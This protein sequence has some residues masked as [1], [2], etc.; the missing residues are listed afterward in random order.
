MGL[1]DRATPSRNGA[2]DLVCLLLFFASRLAAQQYSHLSG[3]IL[4]PSEAGVPGA[5][6]SAINEDTGFR[7]IAYSRSDGGYTVASLEPGVYKITVRKA[8]FR[9]L[10]RF[11]VKIEVSQPARL[12]FTLPVGSMQEAITVEGAAPLLNSED[13]SVG[14]LVARDEIENLPLNGRGLISLIDLAPG[15]IVTPATR[16]EAG[17]FTVNGQRPNT[18]YFMVDGVSAN[19]GVSAGGLPAQSTGGSLP[20]MTAFGSLHNLIALD[21]LDEF[22]I[23]TSSPIPEFGR[24]PGA[25][26]SL[27]SRAGTNEFHGSLLYFFRHEVL[28]AN[29]WF[30]NSQGDP[31]SAVR[32]ND[33]GASFGG[34][35][36]RNRTFFFLSYEGMRMRQPGFWRTAVPTLAARAGLPDFVQP[37]V[38]LFPVP[39]GPDLGA[40][41]AQWTGRNN[42]PSRLDVGSA[43]LDHAFGSRVTAFARFSQSPSSNQFGSTQI[44]ELN[45]NSRSFTVG[46]NIR[47]RHDVVLDTRLNASDA[48][49]H[50]LWR[51][52]GAANLPDCFLQ[53]FTNFVRQGNCHDLFR[54]SL[55]SLDDVI[56]G[57]EGDRRQSQYQFS[58]TVNLN[59]GAH[60]IRAGFDY[61][62]LAPQRHDMNGLV[63]VIADKL[64]D[65]GD[66]LNIWVGSSP[67]LFASSVLR[68]LSVFGQDTW[69]ISPKFSLSY[70]ARWELSTMAKSN[71][72]AYFLDPSSGT[73][74]SEN[75]PIFPPTKG[76]IAPRFGFAYR[77]GGAGKTVI[78][79]GAGL[80]YESSVS[81]ATDLINQGTFSIANL[82]SG[83]NGLF[84][85]LLSWGFLPNLR[86]PWVTN[87]S[88]SVEQALSD[89]DLISLG[90]T[91]S[92]GRNLLRREMGGPGSSERD[93]LALATNHGTSDYQGLQLE[94]RRRLARGLQA[95]AG[96]SWGH[97]ID[98]S[99]T[100]SLLHWA[101][102]GLLPANDKASSDFDV[103]HAMTAAFTWQVPAKPW[104]LR[105]WAL[106]GIFRARTSFP[107]AVL[108][109]DHYV[110]LDF[111]N[112]FRP[113]LVAG[114]PIWIVD[115]NAPGGRRLN[116]SAFKAAASGV[117]GALGRNV[118]SGFGMS[119][120]DLALRR[121]FPFGE[122]CAIQ[123]RVEAFNAMNQANFADP[124]GYL[125]NPLFGQSVSML[126]LM[127]GTGS[128]ASGLAPMFQT[129]GAR[130]LQVSLRLSF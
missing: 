39:N 11:G 101:G 99:S 80:Y 91:G 34:P 64:S 93:F 89:H 105:D 10:M 41:L 23:Q 70:G 115:R 51:Q 114:Q 123:L 104:L 29:D 125:I 111:T 26:I 2:L 121:E 20:G 112:A 60:A 15:T 124:V 8:G 102:S 35:L 116:P 7:R 103:R 4:D 71:Q 72:P 54:I 85:T 61:L 46:F 45:L 69:R 12:D 38:S 14:T 32:L 92:A 128:P 28:A 113:N 76:N 94:Y 82:T 81:I 31:R 27:S 98:N 43:R 5:M 58:Q 42:R 6:I 106:D 36:S 119:Q 83:I 88:V 78:R 50:S 86:L 74:F 120:L 122:H 17:Q 117:Q 16:G 9:T 49:A 30:A 40:G 130:S 109:S 18:H 75:R 87:W 56:Y 59:R 97:S 68:E 33:F 126:N 47:P 66:R 96:Y 107:L 108:D 73:V 62:R 52:V 57:R 118:L 53:P 55:G 100:D 24:L 13:G 19:N 3:L 110:G 37:V 90:Y 127:L 77:P 129:G 22:R 25:Q 79:A 48:S 67:P 84:S 65:L 1:L 63:S 95:R 44:S 21:A